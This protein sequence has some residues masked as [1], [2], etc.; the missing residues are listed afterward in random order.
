MNLLGK[1][2]IWLAGAVVLV[3]LILDQ[4]LKFYIKTHYVL[5]EEHTVLGLDWFR[6]HFTENPGMA[7]GL[8]FGGGTGKIILTWFRI[9]ASAFI[10]YY[11]LNQ[12]K[13]GA[14]T[15]LIVLGSLVLAGALGNIVDSVFYGKIFTESTFFKVATFMGEPSY[16]DWF[17]GKVV[18]MLYFPI[19]NNS[20]YPMW[21]PFKG[22]ESFIFFRPVF[23]LADASITV[24]IFGIILFQRFLFQSEETDLPEETNSQDAMVDADNTAAELPGND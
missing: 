17:K 18:D 21:F 10:V 5:G 8:K 24:G 14:K 11:L 12:I 16:G 1:R 13:E 3:I 2:K 15:G 7:F 22:G 9:A 6:I 4:W 20:Y 19:I 23:N